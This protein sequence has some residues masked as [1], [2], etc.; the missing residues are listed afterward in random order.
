MV[1]ILS[2]CLGICGYRRD[3]I[4]CVEAW[5]HQS[6]LEAHP[7]PLR[8]SDCLTMARMCEWKAQAMADPAAQDLWLDLARR[9]RELADQI[10]GVH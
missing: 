7:L 6:E 2:E 9:W 4:T 8:G 1:T 10:D 3:K 5:V